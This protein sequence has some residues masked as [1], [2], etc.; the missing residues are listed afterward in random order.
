MNNKKK[1]NKKSRGL[2]IGIEDFYD[3]YL[4][5]NVKI[6]LSSGEV[7]EG[8]VIDTTRFFYKVFLKDARVLLINK[9]HVLYLELEEKP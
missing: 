6:H 9:G 1:K 7:V 3:D 8:T 2:K 4:G 5:K